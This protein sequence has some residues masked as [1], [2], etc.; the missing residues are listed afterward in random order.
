MIY[1]V[2]GKDYPYPA[3]V[4]VQ[5]QQKYV[6]SEVLS[7]EGIVSTYQVLSSKPRDKPTCCTYD[8]LPA[9]TNTYVYTC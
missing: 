2:P 3:V 5:Q 7:H 6:D 8:E 4:L 1:L 9:L